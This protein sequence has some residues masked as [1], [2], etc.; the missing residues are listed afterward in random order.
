MDDSE[1]R[2]ER[3]ERR[4]RRLGG[5]TAMLA[6]GWLVLIVWN[7][8]PRPRLDAREFAVR[9][10]AGRRRAALMVRDDGL[11]ALRLDDVNGQPRLYAMLRAD[12]TPVLRLSDSAW[13]HRARFE[14]DEVGRP[15]VALADSAGRTR[16]RFTLDE[17]GEGVLDLGAGSAKPS[18]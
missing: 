6:C 16:A 7:F 13:V 4:V 2:L 14:I 1:I 9:D 8:A 15:R 10:S 3:L 18:R 12:G 5:V 11:P 17:R